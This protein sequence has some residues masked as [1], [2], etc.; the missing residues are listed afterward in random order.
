MISIDE[1]RTDKPKIIC[2]GTHPGIIQSILDYDYLCGHENAS[3][4]AIISKNR[5]WERYFWGEDEIEIPVFT[6]LD[7]LPSEIKQN[8]QYFLNVQSGRRVLTSTKSALDALAGLRGGVIFA[9]QVPEAHSLELAQLAKERGVLVVGPASVGLLIPGVVK[10]GAI[11][12]TMHQQLVAAGI[13]NGGNTA[14][15]STSG[16]MVNELIHTVTGTGLGI[17]FAMALGGDRFPVTSPRDA[18]LLAEA[19]PQTEQI[20]YFGEL[21]GVDEYEIA[22][23]IKDGKVTKRVI[24]YIAGTVAELFETPPQ[25]GHAK[26]M[27][28]TADETA[29]AKKAVLRDVHVE[30]L[31]TFGDLS[32]AVVRNQTIPMSQSLDGGR[33]TIG[34]RR[35]HLIAS[36]VSGDK[37]HEV[38]LLG[39]ELI[40]T[41]ERNSLAGLTLSMLLG[42]QVSSVK[43][44][45]FVDYVLRLLSDHGPYVAG[46]ANTIMSAR[47]GKDLVSSLASGLLTIGPRFG[48][49]INEAA[50]HWL[51]GASEKLDAKE[52]VNE[53]SSRGGL[54][55][56]IGHKKYRVDRPDPRVTALRA[57]VEGEPH[58]YLD[59]A[60]TVQSVTTTKKGTLILNVD[61]AIAAILL[62][63]LESELHYSREQLEELVEIEFFNALFV[64]SRSIGFTA[65]YLDQ[66]RHDEGLLRLS[67]E[68]IIYLG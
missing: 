47:A 10:V 2:L 66:R 25:F 21:G 57:L 56:G 7:T 49:A 24:A 41:I 61:G 29:S 17:S 43:L 63:L 30:V 52:F 62:D 18:F 3:V 32:A 59:F 39:D 27:A 58:K 45:T 67:D 26:A 64:L 19:D 33:R 11:G 65:H 54:I 15:I 36:H 6:D 1:L 50:R 37:N 20:V 13:M 55:P 23:L 68:E 46:A 48:G 31:D 35:K 5:K 12:G 53:F 14:V 40:K 51:R 4:V 9:E 28:Q 8:V 60:L 44:V 38:Q 42:E 16:G 34:L 22:G